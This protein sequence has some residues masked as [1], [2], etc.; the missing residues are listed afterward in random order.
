MTIVIDDLPNGQA[1]RPIPDPAMH[2]DASLYAA[3]S[4]VTARS[5]GARFAIVPGQCVRGQQSICGSKP[6]NGTA[7]AD[8]GY[9]LARPGVVQGWA[10]ILDRGGG[11]DR[12][13]F[14]D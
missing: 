10:W 3:L 12:H 5:T 13:E 8:N 7:L 6:T 11:R 2:I 1:S 9:R 4:E 14:G